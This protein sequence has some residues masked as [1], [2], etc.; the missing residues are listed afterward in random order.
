M[1]PILLARIQFG[2]NISFHILFPTITIALGWVLLFIKLR[3]NATQD[4]AWMNA[5]RFFVK[6]LRALVRSGCR[7]GHHHEL[8][9]R[10][11]LAGLHGA[12]GQ[13]CRPASGL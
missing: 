9:V 10:H 2:A 5:Y 13:H 11:Q 6:G 4:E 3:F 12:R 8:P 7:L 1:D